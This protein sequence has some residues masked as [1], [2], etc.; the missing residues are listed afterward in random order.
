[1]QLR[2]ILALAGW[3]RSSAGASTIRIPGRTCRAAITTATRTVTDIRVHT[4]APPRMGIPKV[5]ILRRR[6]VVHSKGHM[7][8]RHPG[9]PVQAGL[10]HRLAPRRTHRVIAGWRN[11]SP[12]PMRHMTED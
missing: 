12:P 6:M 3:Q 8:R 5:G 4:T 9:R 2:T 7:A 1:M 11:A 10:R